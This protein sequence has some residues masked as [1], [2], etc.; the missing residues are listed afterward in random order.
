[1]IV[2]DYGLKNSMKVFPQYENMKLALL[3]VCFLTLKPRFRLEASMTGKPV[4]GMSRLR[5][6][7]TSKETEWIEIICRLNYLFIHFNS[8]LLLSKV[9]SALIII[10]VNI[11]VHCFTICMLQ[12]HSWPVGCAP[13]LQFPPSQPGR[14]GRKT[15][16]MSRRVQHWKSLK[17]NVGFTWTLADDCSGQNKPPLIQMLRM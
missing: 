8:W 16:K 17:I 1:M 15:R 12:Y 7:F 10:A 2:S 3:Y 13:G 4:R 11:S 14:S 6:L 5:S 9:T